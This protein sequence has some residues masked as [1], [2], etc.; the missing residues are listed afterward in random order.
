MM[1]SQNPEATPDALG[2]PATPSIAP[3]SALS[4]ATAVPE[5]APSSRD[6]QSTRPRN[7]YGHKES[8][9][10]MACKRIQDAI[11]AGKPPKAEQLAQ[12]RERRLAREKA[13]EEALKAKL[14]GKLTAKQ[15][16][17]VFEAAKVEGVIS[18]QVALGK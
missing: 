5:I 7:A 18:G 6:S 4:L 12:S 3:V 2:S 8:C 9:V 15:T 11:A 16:K 17:K 14:R 13:R 1:N 10:C